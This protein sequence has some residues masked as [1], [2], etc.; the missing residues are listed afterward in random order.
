M[1]LLPQAKGRALTRAWGMVRLPQLKSLAPV[2]RK[3]TRIRVQMMSLS[4]RRRRPSSSAAKQEQG[5]CRSLK[6]TATA[7]ETKRWKKPAWQW[8]HHPQLGPMRLMTP[9]LKICAQTR[10]RSQRAL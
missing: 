5:R 4:C 8:T 6:V 7:R 3:I 1:L 2:R 10:W 9:T